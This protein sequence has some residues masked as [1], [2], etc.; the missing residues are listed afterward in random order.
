MLTWDLDKLMSI[1]VKKIN[2]IW[3]SANLLKLIIKIN[4]ISYFKKHKI[5][6]KTIISLFNKLPL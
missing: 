1:K 2:R 3:F 5:Y 6:K 4:L